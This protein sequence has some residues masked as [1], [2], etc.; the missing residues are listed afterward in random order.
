MCAAWS[1]FHRFTFQSN[2]QQTSQGVQRMRFPSPRGPPRPPRP[3]GPP[4]PRGPPPHVL[5]QA[6][7]SSLFPWV[8]GPRPQPPPTVVVNKVSTDAVSRLSSIFDDPSPGR[9]TVLV[10]GDLGGVAVGPAGALSSSS[11]TSFPSTSRSSFS[12]PSNDK[13]G[14]CRDS[15]KK[16]PVNMTKLFNV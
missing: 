10:G 9:D 11:T 12:I 1:A 13:S 8:A 6:Q 7:A 15:N 2:S 3:N 14:K 4:R 16:C 5:Q